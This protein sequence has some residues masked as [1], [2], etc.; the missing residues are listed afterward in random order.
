M[1]G[2]NFKIAEHIY[3]ISAYSYLRA[4]A[5]SVSL[6]ISM[7]VW[8][9]PFLYSK[10]QS[11]RST[12]GFSILFL[13]AGWV[14]SLLIITPSMT[15]L[16][17]IIPPGIF[18][19]LAYLFISTLSFLRFRVPLKTVLQALNAKST[20]KEPQFLENLVPTQAARICL[21]V[22]SSWMSTLRAVSSRILV[23]SSRA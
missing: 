5:M 16:S 20:T 19:I 3:A 21:T 17:L 13:I 8:L 18:S 14:K 11:I 6:V 15:L 4:S 1:S 9:S 23:I 2:L 7:L 22:N 12:L 10:G